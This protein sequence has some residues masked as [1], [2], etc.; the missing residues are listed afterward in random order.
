MI[1]ENSFVLRTLVHMTVQYFSAYGHGNDR[2]RMGDQWDAKHVK[3][4]DRARQKW[5][6]ESEEESE[7]RLRL[8]GETDGQWWGNETEGKQE[9]I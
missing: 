6:A 4:M 1:A 7:S 8:W 5:D 2:G 9:A 3:R